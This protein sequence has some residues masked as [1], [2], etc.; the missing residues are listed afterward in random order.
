MAFLRFNSRYVQ[1][2]T[3]IRTWDIFSSLSSMTKYSKVGTY[4]TIYN[5][6]FIALQHYE[7]TNLPNLEAFDNF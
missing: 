5:D 7:V 2:L 4:P 6:V 1:D 3:Y